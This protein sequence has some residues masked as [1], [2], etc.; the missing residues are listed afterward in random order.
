[1]EVCTGNKRTCLRWPVVANVCAWHWFVF[2]K[3]SQ[4]WHQMLCVQ[5]HH[6]PWQGVPPSFSWRRCCVFPGCPPHAPEGLCS[7]P[8][9]LVG[10]AW[11]HCKTRLGFC[12]TASL[13]A[14]P[15]CARR[16][17]L[18]FCKRQIGRYQASAWLACYLW[19]Y[20]YILDMWVVVFLKADCKTRWL[21]CLNR[22]SVCVLLYLACR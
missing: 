13:P 14:L 22:W 16:G 11:A 2:R 20:G 10:L 5:N 21:L 3:V 9:V 8:S 7:Y 1:M 6:G 17:A 12:L 4:L 15:C 19:M 18:Q